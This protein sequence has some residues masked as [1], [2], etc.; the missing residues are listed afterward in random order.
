MGLFG[1]KKKV[2]EGSAGGEAVLS[3]GS[4]IQVARK[5]DCR[6]DSCPRPQLMTKKAVGEVGPGAVV[7]VMVDNPSSVEALPPMCH[8]LNATHLETIKDPTCWR[9]Y[10]KKD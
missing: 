5:V 1:S 7:E 10:I 8:E 9:V 4:R 6:G 2:E 3:D